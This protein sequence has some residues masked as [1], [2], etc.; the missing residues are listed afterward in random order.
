[1][2]C[3]SPSNI[4]PRN[5]AISTSHCARELV[6]GVSFES[7]ATVCGI[8]HETPTHASMSNEYMSCFGRPLRPIHCSPGLRSRS[9]EK[10]GT[11]EKIE[12]GGERLGRWRFDKV[13]GGA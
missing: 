7:C 3:S 12:G 1:M 8:T 9:F 10:G 2:P 5:A 13:G 6:L 4:Q 11:R